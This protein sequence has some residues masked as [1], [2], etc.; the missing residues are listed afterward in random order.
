MDETGKA[1]GILHAKWITPYQT[2]GIASPYFA[3]LEALEVN[4]YISSDPV[5]PT[6]TSSYLVSPC[7]DDQED[8]SRVKK[9]IIII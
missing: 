5:T 7:S 3:I 6:I 9:H 4:I 1:L 2:Y 8:C